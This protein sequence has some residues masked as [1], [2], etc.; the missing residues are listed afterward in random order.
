MK[1]IFTHKE[2]IIERVPNLKAL[3]L[4]AANEF[5]Q[6]HVITSFS[7]KFPKP[8]LSKRNISVHSVVERT[9]LLELPT[10]LKVTI[11]LFQL[12]LGSIFK[13][14][15]VR[16]VFAGRSALILA[17]ILNFFGFKKY[18]AFVVEY[19]SVDRLSIG[20]GSL[21]DRL[22][23]KGISGGRFFITH[24]DWHGRVIRE[25]FNPKKDARYEILP[26]STLSENLQR[27]NQFFL[28]ERIGVKKDV[29]IILHSGGFGE[30][31]SSAELA[32]QSCILPDNFK[33]VFH[34]SHDISKDSYYIDYLKTKNESGKIIFSKK[35]VSGSDLD[36]LV[37]SA[38]IGVAW[39][40]TSVLGFRAEGMGLAAGKI[41]HYLKCGL[42]VIAT[43]LPSLNYI[44]EFKCGIL[45][46]DLSEL[47]AAIEK[48]SSNHELYSQN[49]I[50]CYEELWSPD[51]YLSNLIKNIKA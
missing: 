3:I 33:L 39:Y 42:P 38:Y 46:Q 47:S 35:P 13:G 5:E 44:E 37:Y 51:R 34:C 45:I 9:K 6:V 19:P 31:F 12:I 16:Y 24:D 8:V 30:W 1:I 40:N 29:R 10:T 49:A 4:C 26:N 25:C 36:N 41:G 50:K 27:K 21:L 48:I 20:A 17:G 15:T 43:K 2:P 18:V 11:Y 28:H 22:E 14:N 23:I 7:N 32:A